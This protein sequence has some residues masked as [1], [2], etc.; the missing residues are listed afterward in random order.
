M[1]KLTEYFLILITAFVGL[2]FKNEICS[3]NVTLANITVGSQ[4]F[5]GF[6]PAL[7]FSH[8]ILQCISHFMLYSIHRTS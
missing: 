3:I 8:E 7:S 4:A 5:D 2:Y 6:S 1:G